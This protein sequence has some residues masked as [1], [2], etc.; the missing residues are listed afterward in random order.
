MFF[1]SLE[2]EVFLKPQKDQV[3]ICDIDNLGVILRSYSKIEI[4]RPG[5]WDKFF[6]QQKILYF[7]GARS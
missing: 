2:F 6:F 7:F 1:A 3:S 5:I 4:F